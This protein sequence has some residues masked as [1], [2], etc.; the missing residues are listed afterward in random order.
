MNFVLVVSTV[1]HG[2]MFKIVKYGQQFAPQ[3]RKILQNKYIKS[4]SQH[5]QFDQKFHSNTYCCS[6]NDDNSNTKD[7]SSVTPTIGSK[8]DVFSDDNATIILD[9][10]EEREKILAEEIEYMEAAEPNVFAGLNTERK[11]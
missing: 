3:C 2:K 10:D 1:L 4:A 6:K 5:N 11:L 8:Y 7:G 9:I